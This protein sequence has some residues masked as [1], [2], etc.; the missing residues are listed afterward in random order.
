VRIIQI[1]NE[2]IVN[3]PEKTST[4][5]VFVP[6]PVFELNPIK[7]NVTLPT[8]TNNTN[9]LPSFDALADPFAMDEHDN[10]PLMIEN[11]F[12]LLDGTNYYPDENL[13]DLGDL[14]ML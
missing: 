7:D 11:V 13:P 10:P 4:S 6:E 2:E 14:D 12:S 9:P 8:V 5:C 3:V 1:K